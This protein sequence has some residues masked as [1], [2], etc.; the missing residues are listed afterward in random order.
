MV[1]SRNLC[2]QIKFILGFYKF[3]YTLCECFTQILTISE[4]DLRVLI[5]CLQTFIVFL[6]IGGNDF[7]K[8]YFSSLY[9]A[10][11]FLEGSSGF[12]SDLSNK[13]AKRCGN[14][15]PFFIPSK[16]RKLESVMCALIPLLHPCCLVFN[17]LIIL[18]R[19]INRFG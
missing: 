19:S 1:I 16:G 11:A 3:I 15:T 6:N 5:Y 7:E 17:N 8:L 18:M 13:R 2:L 9:Q 10:C 4:W 12:K 14:Y